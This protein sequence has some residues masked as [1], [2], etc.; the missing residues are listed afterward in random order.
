MPPLESPDRS[1]YSLLLSAAIKLVNSN[2]SRKNQPSAILRERFLLQL[3]VFLQ[4]FLS[5]RTISFDLSV[6]KTLDYFLAI[7]DTALDDSFTRD[8]DARFKLE[9]I[10]HG[11]GSHPFFGL[12]IT[13]E[14][15]FSSSINFDDRLSS[16]ASYLPTR[17]Q[18]RKI[19][20]TLDYAK[21][22]RIMSLK[23]SFGLLG[24]AASL[25]CS[26]D[27]SCLQ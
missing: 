7:E 15:D 25:F 6:A 13:Q 17:L 16:L 14:E 19:D 9:T 18:R 12:K 22:S 24:L 11:P 3:S 2:A 5:R 21:M 20:A 10:A 8:F 4:H 27:G 1:Y 26:F 23:S